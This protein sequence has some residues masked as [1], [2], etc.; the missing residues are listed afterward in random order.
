LP[1]T[2][3][4]DEILSAYKIS[5]S[6][7]IVP[8]NIDRINGIRRVCFQLLTLYGISSSFCIDIFMNMDIIEYI[9]EFY[10]D[11]DFNNP[12]PVY[13]GLQLLSQVR[14]E[15]GNI[16][17]NNTDGTTTIYFKVIFSEDVLKTKNNIYYYGNNQYSDGDF[18][19]NLVQ[20]GIE[21]I[22]G[23]ALERIDNK[24]FKGEFKIY[25]HDG[26]FNKDGKSFIQVIFPDSIGSS[27]CISDNSDPYN[28]MVNANDAAKFK[29]LDPEEAYKQ[30]RKDQ[31]LKALDINSFK[32]YYDKDDTNF[33]FG[34]PR[35]FR[36]DTQK[37]ISD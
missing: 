9:F 6:R 22:W 26:V 32:Q 14:D 34:N 1:I 16:V 3:G 12:V 13:N 29:D 27:I 8:W 20:Q 4:E 30:Y 21:N 5:N 31:V 33:R 36:N 15:D 7:I 23:E 11:S 35:I 10:K 17:G 37:E 2:E 25:E 28:L 18:T 19:F 24:T